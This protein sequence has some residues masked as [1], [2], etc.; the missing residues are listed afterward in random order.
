MMSLCLW[1]LWGAQQPSC[2]VQQASQCAGFPR[3]GKGRGSPP[4]LPH[5]SQERAR[6]GTPRVSS[7]LGGVPVPV[8]RSGAAP[9]LGRAAGAARAG[10]SPAPTAA[11]GAAQR[12][13]TQALKHLGRGHVILISFFVLNR[14]GVCG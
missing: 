7:V 6:F 9:S 14:K 1:T 4:G 13:M 5:Q 2:I 12:S 8:C 11:R 10:C 3:G